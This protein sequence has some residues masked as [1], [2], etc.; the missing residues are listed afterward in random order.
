MRLSF[1]FSEGAIFL[2]VIFLLIL[3]KSINLY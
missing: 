2:A 3:N 1:A